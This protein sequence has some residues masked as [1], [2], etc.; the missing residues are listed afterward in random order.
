MAEPV[1]AQQSTKR[2]NDA[3]YCPNCAREITDPLPAA[4]APPLSAASVVLPLNL[5][6][7]WEWDK[8]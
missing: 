8:E 3:L 6:L 2:S 4:I 1:D 5:H 7:T